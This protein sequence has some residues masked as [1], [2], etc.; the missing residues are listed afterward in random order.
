VESNGNIQEVVK[1]DTESYDKILGM[2]W[3]SQKEFFVFDLKLSR[4]DQQIV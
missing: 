2:Q 1:L 3:N 4:L